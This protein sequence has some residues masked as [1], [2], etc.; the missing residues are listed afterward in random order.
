MSQKLLK[1]WTI[2]RQIKIYRQF[3]GYKSRL[4]CWTLFFTVLCLLSRLPPH[5]RI[6]SSSRFL[7]PFLPFPPSS[8]TRL[9]CNSLQSLPAVSTQLNFQH[10]SLFHQVF[11]LQ[12]C[13]SASIHKVSFISFQVGSSES[14]VSD[15]MDGWKENVVLTFEN[16]Q[17]SI[18]LMW[19]TKDLDWARLD[20]IKSFDY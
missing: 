1:H 19:W 17:R 8:R 6:L 18:E 15:E 2:V 13:F 5:H 9:I 12:E 10:W 4:T 16:E 14:A 20:W 3:Y 7:P 11:F